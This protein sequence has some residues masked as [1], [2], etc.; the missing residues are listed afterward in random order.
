LLD[1]HQVISLSKHRLGGNIFPIYSILGI[2]EL[3]FYP[4][5]WS[6][7]GEREIVENLNK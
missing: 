1:G 5:K 7:P 4:S 2:S 3:N 6:C